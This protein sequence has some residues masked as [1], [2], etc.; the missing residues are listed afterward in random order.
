MSAFPLLALVVFE[1]A[2]A[3]GAAKAIKPDVQKVGVWKGAK[4]EWQNVD[5][6]LVRPVRLEIQLPAAHRFFTVAIDDTNGVRVRNL[7]DMARTVDFG[8]NTNGTLPQTLS[9]EWNGLDDRG[10]PVPDGTYRVR[11]ISH[12]RVTLS[13]DYTLLGPG[14]P[15]WEGY[16]NSAWGGDHEFPNA[17]ACLSGAANGPWQVA[18]GGATAEGGSPGFVLDGNDRKVFVFGNGWTGP[19]ALAAHDGVVWAGLGRE[20]IRMKYHSGSR[21]PF[22]TATGQVKSLKFDDKDTRIHAL[23]A[24]SSRAALVL[25]TKEVKSKP[26]PD[27][28]VLLN[29][30][31]GQPLVEFS[32]P[33]RVAHNGLT[34]AGQEK[35]L[36]SSDSGILS[37]DPNSATDP[38]QFQPFALPN[39]QKPEALASDK[40]RNLYVYVMAAPISR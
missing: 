2:W 6:S 21:V 14:T 20:L 7:L 9:V 15:P 18:L 32:L 11:G 13:Y 35:L 29:A 31:T 12:P 23:A 39:V 37:W 5:P 4:F 8:G 36:L 17:I 34:F 38:S 28:L 22:L 19:N 16:P 10:E 26:K 25:R 30:K 1:P 27:R 40:D 33:F 3:H 24:N